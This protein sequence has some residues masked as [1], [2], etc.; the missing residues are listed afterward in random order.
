MIDFNKEVEKNMELAKTLLKDLI[1]F[2]TVL[3]KFDE[4]SSSP[5]GEENR[6][7][8]NYLL[9][10]AHEDGFDTKNVDNYAGH[11][12]YG[13]K[14]AKETLGVLAHLDVVQI[15]RASCRERV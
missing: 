4:N 15:G 2:K 5:F 7:I 11:I 3:D 6:K 12:E 8:L 10:F 1:S 14:D 9:A 13:P